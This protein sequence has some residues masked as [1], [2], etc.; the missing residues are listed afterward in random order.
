MRGSLSRASSVC[1]VP[2]I[3]PADAGLT[4]FSLLALA[5]SRD[6]PRGCGAHIV[7]ILSHAPCQGSSP[8]MRGS[9]SVSSAQGSSLGIIPA[10]AG[11]TQPGLLPHRGFWDHPRGC[12]AHTKRSHKISHFPVFLISNLFSLRCFYR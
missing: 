11:L 2:G 12:G 3:I 1:L 6:H 8:R 10:D 7:L 5:T 9:P 4:V